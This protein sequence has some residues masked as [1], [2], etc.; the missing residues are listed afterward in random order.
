MK[1]GMIPGLDYYTGVFWGPREESPEQLAARWLKLIERLQQIDP[2]F[3]HWYILTTW[4]ESGPDAVPF[5]TQVTPLAEKIAANVSTSDSGEPVPILGYQLFAKNN[6][7]QKRGP[8]GF[9]VHMYAGSPSRWTHNWIAIRTD[10]GVVPDSD[11]VTYR[12]FKGA[13]LALA[14]TFDASIGLAYPASLTDLRPKDRKPQRGFTLAWMSYVAPR[15]THLI[16]PPASAIVERRPD[17]GLLMAATD[18]TF[19]TSN[20]SHLA[21]AREIEAA[22]APFNALPYPWES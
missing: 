13:L 3:A 11:V 8:R 7:L 14:E 21:V 4:T 18:E 9:E 2:L 15:F 17:G 1:P 5:D 6:T 20:P 12:I 10:Y 16:T 19:V 22:A